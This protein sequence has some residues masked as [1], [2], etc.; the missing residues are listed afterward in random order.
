MHAAW[1]LVAVI[2][3]IVG[4]GALTV[5]IGMFTVELVGAADP[6]RLPPCPDA[7]HGR[8]RGHDPASDREPARDRE[9]VSARDP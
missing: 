8:G 6:S 5:A 4:A 9:P 3:T 2:A 7:D 1:A